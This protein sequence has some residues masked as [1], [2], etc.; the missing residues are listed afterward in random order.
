LSFNIPKISDE[1]RPRHAK[2]YQV[3]LI[4]LGTA[5]T[6]LDTAANIAFPAITRGLGLSIG[7]IQWVV[8]CYVLTYASLLLVLGRVGDTLG[9]AL[10]F[11]VGLLW[12]AVSLLLVGFSPNYGLLLFFRF[13]QGVGAALVLSCGAALVISIYGE[14]QRGRALGIYTMS[15]SLGMSLGPLAGGALVAAWDWPAVFWFRIP[16]AVAPL[17]LLRGFE[18][19]QARQTGRFDLVGSLALAVGLVAMLMAINRFGELNAILLG[20][21]SAISLAMFVIRESRAT[22][23]IIAVVVLKQPYFALLNLVSVLA[24]LAAFSVWLLVPYFLARVP[25]Y[26]L[27]ESG[28]ILSMAALGAVLAGPIGGRLAKGQVNVRL[29]GATGLILIGIGLFLVG[30]WTEN[31]P[32]TYRLIDLALQGIGLGAFQLAYS[33][34]VTASLPVS[35][36]GVAGSLILLTRTLGWVTAASIVL[37]IFESQNERIGF[38]ESFRQTFQLAALLALIAAGLFAISH[39]R[40]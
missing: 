8:I 5:A 26:T 1:R 10:I 25:T 15:L 22:Y 32:T 21:C 38:L 24:N 36:R 33:D 30:T 9:H 14:H 23:P 18:P 37:T 27:P 7:G 34:L 29:L 39:R 4:G 35:D 12:T 19:L 28:G 3:A 13:L 17:I 16:I 6:Q 11:R 2:A 31:T 20:L 40:A